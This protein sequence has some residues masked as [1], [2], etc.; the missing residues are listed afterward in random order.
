VI[1]VDEKQSLYY[2]PLSE[3][4]AKKAGGLPQKARP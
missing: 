4:E 3:A 2:K 1:E